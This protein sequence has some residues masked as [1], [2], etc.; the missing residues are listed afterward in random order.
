MNVPARPTALPK[1]KP[2]PMTEPIIHYI[3][4]IC[5]CSCECVLMHIN[6]LVQHHTIALA[7]SA[8]RAQCHP[9][10]II[11]P[12]CVYY[13]LC[14]APE[15]ACVSSVRICFAHMLGGRMKTSNPN[16]C[17][18]CVCVRVCSVNNHIRQSNMDVLLPVLYIV[19]ERT[20][21]RACSAA[22]AGW[23]NMTPR[24]RTHR[25]G[26]CLLCAQMVHAGTQALRHHHQHH[27]RALSSP[28][29]EC[30]IRSLSLFAF[31]DCML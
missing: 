18:A 16:S 25:C 5:I 30:G 7:S 19:I 12:I 6:T 20:G 17:T 4:H 9:P 21:E 8:A 10:N 27:H 15:S 31:G 3:Y 11:G 13:L 26:C 1:P 22:A 29:S 14:G 24:A 28:T 23:T 2:L